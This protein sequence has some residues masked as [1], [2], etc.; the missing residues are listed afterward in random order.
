MK[1]EMKGELGV[2]IGRIC[3]YGCGFSL[4]FGTGEEF[5][6][7]KVVNINKDIVAKMML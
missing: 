2:T 5:W 3:G 4:F 7:S 1:L 6:G